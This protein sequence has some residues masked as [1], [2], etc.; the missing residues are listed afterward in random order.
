MSNLAKGIICS[1]IS[2]LMLAAMGLCFKLIDTNISSYEKLLSRGIGL[3]IV[4]YFLVSKAKKKDS[5]ISFL[6]RKQNSLIL[7]ARSAAGGI[8]MLA[9]IYTVNYVSLADADMMIKLNSV[10][11]IILCAIFLNEKF[12]ITQGVI[13]GIS[14]L[15]VTLIIKPSFNNPNLLAYI[16]GLTGTLLVSIAYMSIR[17]LT[18]KENGEHPAT[19]MFHLAV[20]IIISMVIPTIYNF[21]GF[22]GNGIHYIWL[23]LSSIFS[24]IGQFALTYSFKFAPAKEISIYSY[25]SLVWNFVFGFIFFA[26]VPDLWAIIGYTV[27]ITASIYLFFHNK[28]RDT[29]QRQLHSSSATIAGTT[30]VFRPNSLD[31]KRTTIDKD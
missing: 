26:A 4:A 1:L 25:T 17:Y 22:S 27:I 7:L 2:A 18:T 19:I 13:V 10:F 29:K 24:A 9:Y 31:Y 5:N 11:L 12:T 28:I 16:I 3:I 23:A 20:F 15:A 6:G 30:P 21:K 8:A 14:L